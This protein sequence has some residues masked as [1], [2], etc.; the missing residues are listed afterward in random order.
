[1]EEEELQ[2]KIKSLQTE[3]SN[4]IQINKHLKKEIEKIPP[5]DFRG[6]VF[7]IRN[8]NDKIIRI[9]IKQIM[10]VL[11]IIAIFSFFF[12]V[13]YYTSNHTEQTGID[14]GEQSAIGTIYSRCFYLPK[15]SCYDTNYGTSMCAIPGNKT[16]YVVA[17]YKDNEGYVQLR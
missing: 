10:T 11:L 12:W 4:L 14:K 1:M 5:L 16:C 7:T 6:S 15:K 3:N 13:F 9:P 2:K 8:G 17:A